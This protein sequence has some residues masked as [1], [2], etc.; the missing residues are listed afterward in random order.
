MQYCQS[1]IKADGRL[2][3]IA[4]AVHGLMSKLQALQWARRYICNFLVSKYLLYIGE[5][6]RSFTDLTRLS[7]PVMPPNR[8]TR[9]RYDTAPASVSVKPLVSQRT[10]FHCKVFV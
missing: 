3:A 9:P 10:K 4:I 2:V 7:E 5:Q 1:A 8:M 6:T